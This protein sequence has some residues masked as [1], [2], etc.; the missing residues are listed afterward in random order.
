M[1]VQD[2]GV[3]LPMDD[4]EK[5]FEIFHRGQSAIGTSGGGLGLAITRELAEK[6]GGE[7]WTERPVDRGAVFFIYIAKGL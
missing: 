2:D 6:M 1:F 4:E 5:I 3:G 7:V